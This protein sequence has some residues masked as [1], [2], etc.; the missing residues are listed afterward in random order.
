LFQQRQA[1]NIWLISRRSREAPKR[2][3][4][5]RPHVAKVA[6]FDHIWHLRRTLEER[7]FLS[8]SL[9]RGAGFFD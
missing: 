1:T 8:V 6:E 4:R 5:I 9:R 7:R 2:S 3:I